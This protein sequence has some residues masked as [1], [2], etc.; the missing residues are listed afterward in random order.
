VGKSRVLAQQIT[1]VFYPDTLIGI[2][3]H[4]DR[5]Q[6]DLLASFEAIRDVLNLVV[7]LNRRA[8]VLAWP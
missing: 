4:A 3:I 1:T 5:E 8:I 6:I 2:F 7:R